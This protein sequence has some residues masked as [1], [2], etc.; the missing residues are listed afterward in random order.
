MLRKGLEGGLGLLTRT[1]GCN[2][3]TVSPS[4]PMLSAITADSLLSSKPFN[5]L[6]SL[7]VSSTI[8]LAEGPNRNS[9]DDAAASLPLQ[10]PEEKMKLLDE[11]GAAID[12]GDLDE[13]WSIFSSHFPTDKNIIAQLAQMDLMEELEPDE[14]DTITE[15]SNSSRNSKLSGTGTAAPSQQGVIQERVQKVDELGR[16]FA[17]GKRKTSTATVW[18]RQGTGQVIINRRP[19]D[20]YFPALMKRNDVAA[21]F[22]ATNTLGLYDVVAHVQ[23]GGIT[24]QSE[25]LRHGIAHALQNMDPSTRPGLKAAGLLSRDTRQVERKKPGRKKARKK[26]QW[27]KR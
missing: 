3:S 19:F 9:K 25:A 13:A 15:E 1:L 8:A 26:F 6:R 24:G 2:A 27:V 14:E 23:G 12:K 5:T 16:S 11:W 17:V 7:H 4:L 10:S 21:P 18:L 22:I 20:Q